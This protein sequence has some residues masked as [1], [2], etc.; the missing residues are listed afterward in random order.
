MQLKPVPVHKNGTIILVH[1]SVLKAKEPATGL[2][3]GVQAPVD[4]FALNSNSNATHQSN[5]VLLLVLV[6][7]LMLILNA[8]QVKYSITIPVAVNAMLQ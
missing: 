6:N 7:V 1:V 2:K 5:G 8:L 3:S 4:V